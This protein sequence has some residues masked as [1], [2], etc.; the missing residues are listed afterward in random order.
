MSPELL[1][2]TKFGLVESHPTKQSDCYA[3]GMVIYEVL[4]GLKPFAPFGGTGLLHKVL[5]GQHPERPR[6]TQGVG[7]TDSLWGTL[8]RCWSLYPEDRPRLK[9]VLRRLQESNSQSRSSYGERH[10]ETG[11]Y[12]R[13]D[14]SSTSNSGTCYLRSPVHP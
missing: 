14:D 11:T 13:S 12:D 5:D 8:E 4:T 1:N 7:F 3:L 9:S 2:P 10:V 6:G